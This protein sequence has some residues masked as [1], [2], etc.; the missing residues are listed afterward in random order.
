MNDKPL[1]LIS[2]VHRSGSSMMMR[3]FEAGG[4]DVAYDQSQEPL[5]YEYNTPDYTPNPNGFYALQED[6][7]RAGFVRDYAGRVLKYPIQLL[8]KLPKGNYQ[9]V[10]LKRNPDEIL[11]SMAAF[12]PFVAWGREALP[13]VLYDEVVGAILDNLRARGDFNIVVLNYA[14]VVSNPKEVFEQLVK[15]GW[16]LQVE[17]AASVVDESLHRFKLEQK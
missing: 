2:N 11:A 1:Y 16:S 8:T 6:F 15:A 4:M 14:D 10:F 9:L 12:M 5:N 17:G 13:T 7:E 3:A